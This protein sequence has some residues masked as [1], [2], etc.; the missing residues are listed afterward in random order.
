MTTANRFW[1]LTIIILVAIIAAGSLVAWSKYSPNQP[2]EI[3]IPR[4]Q[5]W[6]RKIYIE[7]AV[8]APGLYSLKEGDSLSNLIQAAG[9]TTGS[10]NLSGLKLYIPET[11]EVQPQKVDINRA[12]SW[13]LEAL[14][15]IGEILAQRIVAYRQQYG[16]FGST[17]DLLKVA[18]IGTATYERIKDLISVS[19]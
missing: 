13:L 3:F 9:G 10:A 12:E 11:G 18:G 16:P 4:S 8:T 2:V 1:T 19:D 6:Q 7:G 5:E 17:R 15:G 14:P